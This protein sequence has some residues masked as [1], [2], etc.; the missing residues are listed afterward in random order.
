MGF[1]ASEF[2]FQDTKL[3]NR[4][5]ELYAALRITFNLNNV[6]YINIFDLLNISIKFLFG[7]IEFLTLS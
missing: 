4:N 3:K 5:V 6:I 1:D 7:L 2:W